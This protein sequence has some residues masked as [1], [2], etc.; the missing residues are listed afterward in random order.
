M[1]TPE[2]EQT[3]A[4]PFSECELKALAESPEALQALVDYHDW[5]GTMAD[6]CDMPSCVTYHQQRRLVLRRWLGEALNKREEKRR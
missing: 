6:A 2:A 1:P 4:L 3:T 5:Q